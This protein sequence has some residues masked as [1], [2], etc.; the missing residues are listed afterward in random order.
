[1]TGHL[2]AEP[3]ADDDRIDFVPVLLYMYSTNWV[4]GVGG[5]N[6]KGVEGRRPEEK[7]EEERTNGCRWR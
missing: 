1:M 5:S 3:L 7:K 4:V 6:T 2:R